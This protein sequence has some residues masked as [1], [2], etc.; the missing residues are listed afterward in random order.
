MAI[1]Q[2]FKPARE[3]SVVSEE[4]KAEALEFIDGLR[5]DVMDGKMS[6]IVIVGLERGQSGSVISFGSFDCRLSMMGALEYA[7]VQLGEM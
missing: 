4:K 2:E 6:G 1:I 5:Q 7:K 3:V